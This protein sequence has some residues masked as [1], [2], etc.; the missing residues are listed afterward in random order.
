MLVEKEEMQRSVQQSVEGSSWNAPERA[1]LAGP[2]QSAPRRAGARPTPEAIRAAETWARA[3]GLA[4][5]HTA[6]RKSASP[7]ADPPRSMDAS[8]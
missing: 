1:G 2:S 7:P 3:R 8:A 5:L 6:T 4:T